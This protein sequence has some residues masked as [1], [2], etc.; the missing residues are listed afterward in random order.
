MTGL[1]V[2]FLEPEKKGGGGREMKDND[3]GQYCFLPN[4]DGDREGLAT[5]AE[6]EKRGSV[7]QPAACNCFSFLIWCSFPPF[8][9]NVRQPL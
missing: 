9:I 1:V 5:S 3:E 4:G 6:Q 7:A 2:S 8:L